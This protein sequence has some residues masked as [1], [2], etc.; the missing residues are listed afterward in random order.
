[1]ACR[2]GGDGAAELRRALAGDGM[3]PRTPLPGRRPQL[4]VDVA[5]ESQTYAVSVGLDET[6]AI[7]AGACLGI[8]ELTRSAIGLVAASPPARTGAPEYRRGREAA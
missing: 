5:F 4:T 2:D 3:S 8:G 7:R 1:M 6:G